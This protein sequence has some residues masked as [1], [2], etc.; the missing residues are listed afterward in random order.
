MG[1]CTGGYSDQ[2]PYES[3]PDQKVDIPHEEHKKKWW[4]LSDE[5]KKQLEVRL[6][7]LRV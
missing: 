6:Q 3:H 4:D 5:R 1:L 7:S 2:K